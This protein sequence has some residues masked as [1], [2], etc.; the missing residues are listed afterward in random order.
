MWG[1]MPGTSDHTFHPQGGQL[2]TSQ[3]HIAGFDF[4]VYESGTFTTEDQT[5]AFEKIWMALEMDLEGTTTIFQ[6]WRVWPLDHQ[7]HGGLILGEAIDWN[8]PWDQWKAGN[9]NL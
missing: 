5:L 8:I 3:G 6:H 9:A 2:P 7:A 4:E 1:A